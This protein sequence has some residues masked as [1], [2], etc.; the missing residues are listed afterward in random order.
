MVSWNSIVAVCAQNGLPNEAFNCFDMMRVNGFFP[1]EA[2][3]VSL[4]QA[5]DN[6]PLGRSV[7][8][9]HGV[10]FTCGLDGNVTIVTTL[11]NLYS[12]LGRLND[13]RKVFLEISKPD[14]V[15]WTAMLAGYA[16]HGRGKEAVE[17]FER[18]VKEEGMDPDHVTFTHLLSACSH[19]GLVKEGKYYFKIMSDVYKIQPR[20]DHYSCMV[21][22]L[23]RCGLLD[24][25][26]ELIKNMPFEPNSGVWGALLGACRVH[27]NIDLGKKAA[28]NLIVLAPSDPRNYIM[29]CN[30]Y[31]AAGLWSDASKVRALMK[32]KVLTRNPG[33]SFIEHGNKIHRFVVDDYTHPDSHRIHKKLEEVMRKIQEVGFVPETESVLHDVDEEVKMDMITKHSEKIALAYGLL[34]SSADFPL[35]II[36]NLRICRD[37]HNTAK[38]VSMVEKRTIIIRDTKRFHQFS[39]GL[40]SCGDYW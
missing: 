10:I 5:C 14:K 25:A 9:L 29:L 30:M 17:F 27:R 18:V 16:M 8:A 28:E 6:L 13:S 35:V 24:D 37:C 12:K 19:S 7:E 36:K 11:L 4:L 34:V 3:M 38:F 22:L 26:H 39:D 2:T 21:D 20:L 32:T 23:G 40:C 15:A 31:S 1:D 33:C